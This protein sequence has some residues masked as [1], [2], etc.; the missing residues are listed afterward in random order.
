M[1]HFTEIETQ[2]K[3]IEALRLACREVGL[4]L[5]QNTEARGYYENYTKGEF[6]IQL[7]PAPLGIGT[8]LGSKRLGSVPVPIITH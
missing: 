4:P 7:K 2:I 1:T 5:L 3:D 6:V 8:G